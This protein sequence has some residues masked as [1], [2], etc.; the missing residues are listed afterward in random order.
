MTDESKKQHDCIISEQEMCFG[1][2]RIKNKSIIVID[3]TKSQNKK[4]DDL[5]RLLNRI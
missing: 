4:T 1:L 3:V 2:V 5:A